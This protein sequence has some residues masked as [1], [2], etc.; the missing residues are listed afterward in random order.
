MDTAFYSIDEESNYSA[1][2]PRQKRL[3]EGA[4]IYNSLLQP[5]R[6]LK[7]RIYFGAGCK[8]PRLTDIS[9]LDGGLTERA[10][11]SPTCAFTATSLVRS[12]SEF[13]S[14]Y[15]F[16]DM[17]VVDTGVRYI[18]LTPDDARDDD[19][20]IGREY[21]TKEKLY[22]ELESCH[23][24]LLDNIRELTRKKRI[25][26]GKQT[27]LPAEVPTYEWATR[28]S[29]RPLANI[30]PGPVRN[31][32]PEAVIIAMHW[33]QAGGAERWAME[34]I[35]I[36]RDAGLVPVVITS[37]DGHQPW[38]TDSVLDDAVVMNL[39]FPVQE[40]PGDE[41]L[42]RALFEQFNIRGILIHHCQWMYDRLWWVKKYFSDTPVVDSLHIVEY[43]WRGGFP[44]E[45][46]SHDRFV[47]VH[48]VIS[49]QLVDWMAKT[50]DV[51]PAKIIDAPLVD[52]TADAES[53]KFKPRTEASRLTLAFVGRMNRQKRPDAF[54]LLAKKLEKKY[55]G[56]YR[57]IL[58]GSGDIDAVADCMIERLGLAGVV[59]R[60][61]I[62]I[63]VGK[64]YRDADV[65]VVSSV[66]E[67]ITL[68]SFEAISAGVPVIST[69]VG[70]QSTVIPPA[71]LLG[72]RTGAFLRKAIPLLESM[73]VNEA[74]RES[75]WSQEVDMVNEF[76]R[77][78][79][80]NHLFTR[81]VNDWK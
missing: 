61:S 72:M 58:H 15:Y 40:R 32:A 39:T 4:V 56:Q 66:N 18:A 46:V 22:R 7:Y 26:E 28:K 80:A 24:L 48:H 51:N 78:E 10:G 5:G 13:S 45:A 6:S 63:P 12:N 36:V 14:H 2:T 27:I 53:L 76:S 77:L 20:M 55:P 62:D 37:V 25:Q 81:L 21:T 9:T 35:K 65:L 60:R 73:R 79:T 44:A 41:P 59:E 54:V 71:A 50:H 19:L 75:I 11:L 38:I 8:Y 33:L 69:D 42:L 16:D 74:L 17:P 3:V 43:R 1:L 57:F 23:P 31:E 68:T 52:L 30:A 64:T 34:T 49:P 29:H 47:D 70:S 67:G